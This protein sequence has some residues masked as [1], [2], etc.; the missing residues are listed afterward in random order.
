MTPG[1]EPRWK[2]KLAD[3]IVPNVKDKDK[4]HR[5]MYISHLQ[6][7]DVLGLF[8]WLVD[9]FVDAKHFIVNLLR[10]AHTEE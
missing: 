2:W 3:T 5:D 6:E 7:R 4:A 8:G 10:Q 9:V 1:G